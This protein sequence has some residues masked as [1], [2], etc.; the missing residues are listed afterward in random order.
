[1]SLELN[2][3]RRQLRKAAVKQRER[4]ENAE[5]LVQALRAELSAAVSERDELRRQLHDDTEIQRSG[6]KSAIS[7]W[8]MS[9]VLSL[10][11]IVATVAALLGAG[12]YSSLAGVIEMEL[13]P[14]LSIS[15]CPSTL[16]A[17]LTT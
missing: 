13:N 7:S 12:I 11:G 15:I 9:E 3:T 14:P 4:A 16:R 5:Q 6:G 17:L 8:S 1:M 2:L 10:I